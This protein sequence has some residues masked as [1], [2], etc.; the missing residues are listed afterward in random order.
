LFGPAHSYRAFETW[1]KPDLPAFD[2]ANFENV[3][4]YCI[5]IARGCHEG[6]ACLMRNRPAPWN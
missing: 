1:L 2:R 6:I 4:G 3:V 5:A